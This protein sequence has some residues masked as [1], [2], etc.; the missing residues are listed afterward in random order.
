MPE[1]I[2]LLLIHGTLVTMDARFTVVDDGAVAIR[3]TSIV[4]VGPSAELAD[5]FSA[6]VTVD[7]AGCAILPGL[8][9]GHAHVPMSLLRGLVA[10]VQLD[11]WLFGYM[12]PVESSF[13]TPEFSYTGALLSCAELIRSGTTTFVDMYYFEEEVARAAD[14]AGMRAICGQTVMRLPTPDAPS[15]DEGLERARRFIEEWHL[16]ERIV[17]T[18]APHAPYTCT[19]EIYREAVALCRRYGVPLVTHLSETAREVEESRRERSLTPIAYAQSVGAFEVHCICAHCVHATEDDLILLKRHGAGAVPCPTSNL[20]LA[21]G[22]APY[23]RLIESGVKTGLGTDGPASNDDQDLWSEIHLAALLPK[24][25]SGDPTVVPAREALALATCWGARA[26]R[27]DHLVGSLEAGKRADIAVVELGRLHSAPRYRYSADAVYS[28]LVYGARA[29]DVRHTLVDGRFLLRDK[30]LTTLDEQQVIASAQAL[31]DSIDAFLAQREESLLDKI[32]A[33]GGV[34]AGEIFEVQ[35]KA[36]IPSVDQIAARIDETEAITVAKFTERTQYDTYFSFA[37]PAR[38]RI[39]LRE[40]HRTDP[41]ARVQPKHAITLTEAASIGEYPH[42]ILL[43]R[44]RYSAIADRT[45]RFY[46]EYFQPDSVTEIEKRRRRWRIIY[47]GED[48]ALNVDELVH[49]VR[50]GPYLEIKSRTWSRRDAE[51]KAR[52]IGEL[53]ELFGVDDSALVKQEYVDL[54]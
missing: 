19:D 36:M 32:L 14:E 18:I 53:L 9:N 26:T 45:P 1:P 31:A 44:A 6:A 34:D 22:V 47:K 49:H 8:I 39:R 15:Y 29:H 40:D 38:G 3:G 24:G 25:L 5:R 41:G 28:H 33:I 52:L 42:A 37:D 17:P 21:S 27:L 16:H 30:Q 46:R 11:V 10:D 2:D 23:R 51:D 35:V 12:F 48:F 43:S 20:K 54:S 13:V 4:A 50:P 7:C